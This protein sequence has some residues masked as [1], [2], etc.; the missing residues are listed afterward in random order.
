MRKKF[1]VLGFVFWLIATVAL[2]FAGRRILSPDWPHVVP[3]FTISFIAMAFVIRLAC[4][5]AHLA[6]DQWP[7]AAVSLL[8]PTLLLDPFS[9]AFFPA[10]FPNMAPESAGVFG[11]WMI[12]CCAGGLVGAMVQSVPLAHEPARSA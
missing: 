1:I 8:L 12:V 4:R 9:S 3:L 5:R 7:Q 11:G 10:V 6:P 2:R